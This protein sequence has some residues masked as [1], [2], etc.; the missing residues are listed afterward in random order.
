MKKN[1]KYRQKKR[2][3]TKRHSTET[4]TG[5]YP[6]GTFKLQT[7]LP[8]VTIETAFIGED[9]IPLSFMQKSRMYFCAVI[10]VVAQN[11]PNI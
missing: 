5:R 7:L 10:K 9:V 8:G 3:Q 11:D 2:K 6:N 4:V 1:R